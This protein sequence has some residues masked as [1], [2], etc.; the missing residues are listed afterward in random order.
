MLVTASING[1]PQPNES[2]INNVTQ[3]NKE[4]DKMTRNAKRQLIKKR[5]DRNQRILWVI[6]DIVGLSLIVAITYGLA[7][8]AWGVAA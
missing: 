8:L 1:L 2:V 7:M 3:P 5:Q 6:Q 4:S